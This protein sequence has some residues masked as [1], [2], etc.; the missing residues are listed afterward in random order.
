MATMR[1]M[2][3]NTGF[4]ISLLSDLLPNVKVRVHISALVNNT[5]NFYAGVIELV[6]HDMSA[7]GKATRSWHNII[8]LFAH[9]RITGQIIETGK[10]SREI[11]LGLLDAPLL[12]GIVPDDFEVIPCKGA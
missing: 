7:L 4:S 11:A 3:C 12:K 9:L 10:E 1:Y 2:S 5:D 6:E 8:P